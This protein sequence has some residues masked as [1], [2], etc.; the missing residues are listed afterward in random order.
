MRTRRRRWP[1]ILLVMTAVLIVVLALTPVGTIGTVLFLNQIET[2]EF[3]VRGDELH[4]SGE[5]NSK[6]L[7]QFLTVIDEHPNITTLVELEVP[8]SLDDDTM[9]ALGYKVRELGLDTRLLATSAIDSGGV[10][11]FLA[12]VERTMQDGAHI[13]VHSWSDGQREATDYPRN[14]PEHEQ[15]RAYIEEM[16][17][18]D[19]F[20]WFT[21]EAAPADGIYPMTNAEIER[22]GLLTGSI[23][24]SG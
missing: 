20:Y 1:L 3:E 15:N 14:A 6:T 9:I 5:I 7:D 13:G 10:D 22:F 18:T 21:I 19:E 2:T 11:L 23:E 17:G 4:M 24:R 8:G 16:L 12:G